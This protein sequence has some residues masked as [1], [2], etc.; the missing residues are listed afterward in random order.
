MPAQLRMTDTG[1]LK[2]DS[3]NPVPPPAAAWL[4]ISR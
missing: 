1:Y 4:L 2:P 3:L